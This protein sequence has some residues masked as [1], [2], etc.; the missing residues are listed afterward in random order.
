[1]SRTSR[2]CSARS[3]VGHPRR[4]SRGCGGAGALKFAVTEAVV[5]ALDPVRRRYAAL[6]ADPDEVDRVL[7]AGRDAV[8]P[9]AVATTARA[10]EAIG[11]LGVA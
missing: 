10:R 1:M 7:R 4:R 3:R 5:A 11:L 9:R 2:P 6:A 8:A